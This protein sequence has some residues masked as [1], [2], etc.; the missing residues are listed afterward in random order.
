VKRANGPVVAA[1]LAAGESRRMGCP[2][3]LL[4]WGETTVLGRTLQN[5]LASR[6]DEVLVVTGLEAEAVTREAAN[7]SV[8][9]IYNPDYASAEMLS[10]LQVAVRALPPGCKGV[11]VV[12]ADQPLIPTA[13]FDQVIAAFDY[14]EQRIVAPVFEGQRGHPVLFGRRFFSD[15]LAL[16]PGSAPRDLLRAHPDAVYLIPVESDSILLDL[17]WPA[18]Y[19]RYRPP[20][21]GEG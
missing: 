8:K 17:D 12:L 21:A 3:P 9:A 14:N 11:L 15:L 1:V 16:P 2:K 7:F 20:A 10:S 18:E 13:V 4:A 19:E 6:I 5:L